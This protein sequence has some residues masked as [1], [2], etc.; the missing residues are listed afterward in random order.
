[1]RLYPV[2]VMLLNELTIDLL[3]FKLPYC[4][5][6]SLFIQVLFKDMRPLTFYLE[7]SRFSSLHNNIKFKTRQKRRNQT[8]V[9]N[10]QQYHQDISHVAV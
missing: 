7:K 9:T 10:Q 8:K 4:P 6:I 5:R 2:D 1:M 3:A